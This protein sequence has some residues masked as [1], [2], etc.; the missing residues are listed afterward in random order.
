MNYLWLWSKAPSF[1]LQTICIHLMLL[2]IFAWIFIK[3]DL[4]VRAL[5]EKVKKAK[6]LSV[7]AKFRD[8]K[9][10]CMC[11]CGSR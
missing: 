7:M 8:Q 10:M 9:H 3:K 1:E 4:Q 6:R 11:V 2:V 5:E